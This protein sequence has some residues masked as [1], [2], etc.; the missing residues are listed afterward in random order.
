M[1]NRFI[2]IKIW[3]LIDEIH[4]IILFWGISTI[5]IVYNS[6]IILT[7][8]ITILYST[9]FIILS[10]TLFITTIHHPTLYLHLSNLPIIFILIVTAYLSLSKLPLLSIL[11]SDIWMNTIIKHRFLWKLWYIYRLPYLFYRNFILSFIFCW[12]LLKFYMYLL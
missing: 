2:F 7:I 10:Y 11:F 3:I 9:L 4:L 8:K 5:A 12:I 6:W 1:I